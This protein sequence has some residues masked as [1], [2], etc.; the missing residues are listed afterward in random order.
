MQTISKKENSIEMSN[1]IFSLGEPNSEIKH[2]QISESTIDSTNL[3]IKKS[4]A[5]TNK[6]TSNRKKKVFNKTKSLK[7]YSVVSQASSQQIFK[8]IDEAKE[9]NPNN[10]ALFNPLHD[11]NSSINQNCAQMLL[12]F[13]DRL[14]NLLALVK[15]DQNNNKKSIEKP[16]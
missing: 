13:E 6:K 2:I 15:E 10:A 1:S 4:P 7:E 16:S 3:N 8:E 14:G 5:K 9:I 11:I 12:A